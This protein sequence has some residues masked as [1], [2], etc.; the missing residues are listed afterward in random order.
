MDVWAWLDQDAQGLEGE[1]NQ[2]KPGDLVK[3]KKIESNLFPCFGAC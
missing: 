2:M 3:F 1:G